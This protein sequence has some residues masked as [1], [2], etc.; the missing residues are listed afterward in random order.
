[1]EILQWLLNNKEA[2]RGGE[3]EALKCAE[4]RKIY[5]AFDKEGHLLAAG[6]KELCLT[7]DGK[8]I[9]PFDAEGALRE[10]L[11]K[12]KREGYVLYL[13]RSSTTCAGRRMEI[14]LPDG[15]EVREIICQDNVFAIV[16]TDG[17][18]A[19]FGAFNVMEEAL[20]LVESLYHSGNGAGED[21]VSRC[22]YE[23]LAEDHQKYL[24]RMENEKKVS[25]ANSRTAK[26]GELPQR[27]SGEYV[28]RY[29]PRLWSHKTEVSASYGEK[30]EKPGKS[31]LIWLNS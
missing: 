11:A 26:R 25:A 4:S 6:K 13:I 29:M 31:F 28:C 7:G 3:H 22:Y 8:V 20:M 21:A 14:P 15:F 1:M 12:E 19:I 5:H 10:N 23:Y 17:D 16:P 9:F 2:L 24:Q 18:E 27:K 30:T